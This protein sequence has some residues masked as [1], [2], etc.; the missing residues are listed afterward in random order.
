MPKKQSKPKAPGV[1]RRGAAKRAKP[2]ALRA[3]L[4]FGLLTVFILAAGGTSAAWA[5]GRIVNPA[6][7]QDSFAALP[8]YNVI[9]QR[10]DRLEFWPRARYHDLAR[11]NGY[12]L[13]YSP[14]QALEETG[15]LDLLT[16]L[17]NTCVPVSDISGISE[18]SDDMACYS[19]YTDNVICRFYDN[20]P[21][22][23]QCGDNTEF[24]VYQGVL[25]VSSGR[26]NGTDQLCYTAVITPDSSMTPATEEQ[27]EEAYRTILDDLTMLAGDPGSAPYYSCGPLSNALYSFVPW[28]PYVA[29][30]VAEPIAEEPSSEISYSSAR[31]TLDLF[32]RLFISNNKASDVSPWE[33]QGMKKPDQKNPEALERFLQEY[34]QRVYFLDLQILRQ[35]GCYLILL[36]SDYNVLG[37][38]YDPLLKT[39]TGFGIQ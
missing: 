33:E 5:A 8:V 21:V 24:S 1:P 29:Q 34:Y 13:P 16:M 26:G 4:A 37:F 20:I 35:D 25:N 11:A 17:M 18:R 9:G 28:F 31:A 39:Y 2:G 14:Q 30:A 23:V 38:Y 19:Y 27:Y 10:T 22:Q 7:Q 3:N 12:P 36:Q 6:G 32:E 15:F